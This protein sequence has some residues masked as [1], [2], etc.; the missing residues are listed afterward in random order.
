VFVLMLRAV[1]YSNAE[2]VRFDIICYEYGVLHTQKTNIFIVIE[3]L[4]L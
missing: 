1:T 4:P 2:S 3:P